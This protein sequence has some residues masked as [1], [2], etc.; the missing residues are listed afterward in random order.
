MFINSRYVSEMLEKIQEF[1]AQEIQLKGL[2][3]KI[4]T[5]KD[6]SS[7]FLYKNLFST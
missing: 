4:K 7:P 1:G 5:T 3:K 6:L 2:N